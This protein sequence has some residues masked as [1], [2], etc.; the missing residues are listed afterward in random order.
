M[1]QK[2]RWAIV[3]LGKISRRMLRAIRSVEGSEITACASSSPQRAQEYAQKYN[4]P[5]AFTYEELAQ[6]ADKVDAAYIST[7]MN[8][9]EKPAVLFLNAKIPVLVEKSFAVNLASAQ[10]MITAAKQNDTLIMEALWTRFLPATLYVQEVLNSGTLGAPTSARSKFEVGI[11]HGPK[12]R[13]FNKAVGGGSV[14]DVG[15]YPTTYTHMLFGM[16]QKIEAKGKIKNEVEINC[17]TVFTYENGLVVNFRV[18]HEF[19]T[20]KEYYTIEFEKGQ[21]HIPSFYDA[22]KVIVKSDSGGKTVKKFTPRRAR[23]GF[24]WE[25]EHF[26]QLIRD[27]LKESPVMTHQVT[28]EVMQLIEHQLTQVG[29]SYE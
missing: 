9:H 21:I 5:H 29:V 22:R 7:H 26:N 4:I 20:L 3:G 6:N 27:N 14:L 15:V 24:T 11:G 8:A 28:L 25:I 18:S 17:D 2:I 19:L 10:R 12:S 16:P 1:Q 23:D 13:V